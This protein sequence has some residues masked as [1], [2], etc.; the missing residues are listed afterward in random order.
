MTEAEV[1]AILGQPGTLDS[2]HPLPGKTE[3]ERWMIWQVDHRTWA[4]MGFQNDRV[5][6]GTSWRVYLGN[7]TM[8]EKIRRWLQL[9]GI[10][11]SPHRPNEQ[12]NM[13]RL[14]DNGATARLASWLTSVMLI[15]ASCVFRIRGTAV[16][17]RSNSTGRLPGLEHQRPEC[18]H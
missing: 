3:P 16:L 13:R 12:A 15:H 4:V 1:E 5:S 6:T 8:L 9:G 18:H 7:E 11:I 14:A 10:S 17:T 2:I